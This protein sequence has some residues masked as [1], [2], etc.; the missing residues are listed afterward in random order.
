MIPGLDTESSDEVYLP[1]GSKDLG[2]RFVLLRAR[3]LDPRPLCDCEA[4]ALCEYLTILS[5]GP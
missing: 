1:R 3:E 5:L 4:D 2:D